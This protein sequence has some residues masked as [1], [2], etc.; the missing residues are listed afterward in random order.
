MNFR[1]TVN[2]RENGRDFVKRTEI[3]KNEK[4]AN[5][6]PGEKGA[7]EAGTVDEGEEAE[8]ETYCSCR[9]TARTGQK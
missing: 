4:E 8:E 3:S 7:M 6:A 1:I 5:G 9:G 2:R